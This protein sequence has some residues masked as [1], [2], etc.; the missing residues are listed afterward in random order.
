MFRCGAGGRVAIEILWSHSHRVS[1]APASVIDR[2]AIG[3]LTARLDRDFRH[4]VIM[5]RPA[6]AP[7]MALLVLTSPRCTGSPDEHR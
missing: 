1:R 7:A 2:D 6:L 3:G 5:T 4:R